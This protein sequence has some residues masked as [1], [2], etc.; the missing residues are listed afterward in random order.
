MPVIKN[1]T[2]ISRN[3]NL[4]Y[5]F[6]PK[7]VKSVLESKG[8]KLGDKVEWEVAEAREGEIKIVLRVYKE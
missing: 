5:V 3:G 1:V 8:I 2:K 6:I 4:W 7:V